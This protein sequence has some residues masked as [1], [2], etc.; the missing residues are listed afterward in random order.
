MQF[1]IISKIQEMPSYESGWN[2]LVS[3]STFDSIFATYEW[4]SSWIRYYGISN[5]LKILIAHENNRLCGI[6]PLYADRKK[7][8]GSEYITLRSL[9]NWHSSK[10]NFIVTRERAAEIMRLSLNYLTESMRWDCMQMEYVP[11][12]AHSISML[13]DL[14]KKSYYRIILEDR[15]KSPYI[16][17]NGTWEEYLQMRGKKLRRNLDYFEKRITKEGKK[18]VSTIENGDDLDEHL[19]EALKIEKSSWKGE[20]GTAIAN[21]DVDT[22]FYTALARNMSEKDHFVLHFLVVSGEKI[23]FCYGLKYKNR[24]NALKI[25]YDPQYAQLS[26]GRVLLKKIVQNLYQDSRYDI[27]DFLGAND[28]WKTKWTDKS[29]QMYRMTLLIRRSPLFSYITFGLQA[30][31]VRDP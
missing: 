19:R 20:E 26:P 14:E 27:F 10:F 9:S 30:R 28:E 5:S 13:K 12:E 23:A 7:L 16:E 29:Q 21:S 6:L 17:L 18:E 31:P 15:M 25:G 2:Q 1:E 11:E 8:Y 24:F 4:F 22:N 3:E